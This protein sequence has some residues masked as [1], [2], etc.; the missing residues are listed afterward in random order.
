M[1]PRHVLNADLG[2]TLFAGF[3]KKD[4][5][6]IQRNILTLQ[7]Q[8]HHE[9]RN[10]V[11]LVVHRSAAI[12]MTAVARGAKR[13]VRPLLRIDVDDVGV[14]HDEDRPPGAAALEPREDVRTTRLER[15]NLHRDALGFEHFLQ[16][17]GGRLL[18]TW[19]IRSVH[20][21]ERLE[22]PECFTV[23]GRPVRCLWRL[24]RRDQ[25]REDER[26]Y[27]AAHGWES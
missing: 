15:E 16:V 7:R 12:D 5:V 18:V 20:A 8:H 21:N 1:L 3:G 22:V 11:V 19:R 25:T 9:R 17:L 26:H 4:N 23:E 2:R 6:A 27:C 10:H 13:R 24:S 14:A